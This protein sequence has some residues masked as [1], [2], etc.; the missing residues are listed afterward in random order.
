MTQKKVRFM[1]RG[2]MGLGKK[3]KTHVVLKVS[4]IDWP[5]MIK[6]QKTKDLVQLWAK[7]SRV[8]R[9]LKIKNGTIPA[10]EAAATPPVPP[11]AAQSSQ[12]AAAAAT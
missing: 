2:R 11:A 12:E 10:T 8:T 7:R 4:T 6:K 5:E 3:K 9:Y 1:G